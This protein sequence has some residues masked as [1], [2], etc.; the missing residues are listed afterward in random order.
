MPVGV[1]SGHWQPLSAGWCWYPEQHGRHQVLSTASLRSFAGI[2]IVDLGCCRVWNFFRCCGCIQFQSKL[3]YLSCMKCVLCLMAS[4]AVSSASWGC[5][6]SFS[7]HWRTKGN[8]WKANKPKLVLPSFSLS[9]AGLPSPGRELLPCVYYTWSRFWLSWWG[10]NNSNTEAILHFTATGTCFISQLLLYCMPYLHLFSFQLKY[11]QYVTI[12]KIWPAL[13]CNICW[14]QTRD[15]C[16]TIKL[17]FS[18]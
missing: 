14:V 18:D 9:P 6:C 17:K 3:N 5:I 10:I 8:I 16:A 1:W 15:T 13:S 2:W 12:F 4:W 11:E 7:S